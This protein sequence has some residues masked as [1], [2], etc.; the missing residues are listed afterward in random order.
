MMRV[1]L[2]KDLTQEQRQVI[3][4]ERQSLE[5]THPELSP[6]SEVQLDYS[7]S[8]CHNNIVKRLFADVLEVEEL[9]QI[10][11][12]FNHNMTNSTRAAVSST[13]WVKLWFG[14]TGIVY[15]SVVRPFLRFRAANHQHPDYG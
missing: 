12:H 2:W 7:L 5:R 3:L 1:P 9:V 8:A 10:H 6:P 15:V 11:R 4:D 14:L 13:P